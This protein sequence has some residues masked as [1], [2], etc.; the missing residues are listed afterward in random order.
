MDRLEK[1]HDTTVK[2][3]LESGAMARKPSLSIFPEGETTICADVGEDFEIAV[4]ARHT[5]GMSPTRGAGVQFEV[6]D[7]PL[8]LGPRRVRK[9]TAEADEEGRASVSAVYVKRGAATVAVDLR[10]GHLGDTVFFGGHS[11]GMTHR[12]TVA[13]WALSTAGE[14][15]TVPISVNALD[16]HNRPVRAADIL[17]E[18]SLVGSDNWTRLR[19][20]RRPDGEY[21]GALRTVRAGCWRLR[22]YD[23]ITK[24]VGEG[25]TQ[26][27]AA[28]PRALRVLEAPDPRSAPPFGEVWLRARLEDAH[29][30][31][32][33]PH[34]VRC[35]IKGAKLKARINLDGSARFLLHRP[36]GSG[37]AVANLSDSGRSGITA[38]HTVPF[39]ACWVGNPGFVG[40]GASF[41]TSVYIMPPP[42]RA[43]RT[44]TITLAFEPD[45]VRLLSLEPESGIAMQVRRE[46]RKVVAEIAFRRP[47]TANEVP[48]GIRIGT[49]T[50]ECKRGGST[51]FTA[52]AQMSPETEPWK[53]CISQKRQRQKC[54]CINIINKEADLK[55]ME[56]GDRAMRTVV[57]ILSTQNI[58]NCCP[59]LRINIHHCRIS[60]ADWRTKVIPAVGAGGVVGSS[61]RAQSP[62]TE[63]VTF[64]PPATNTVPFPSSSAR[65][66][67]RLVFRLPVSCHVPVTGL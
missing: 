5:P 59:S 16:L 56:A 11:D 3:T 6:I 27:L 67:I 18:A 15:N 37:N 14:R 21:E 42:R 63:P 41:E 38:I 19:L 9:L 47:V 46:K 2:K 62:E 1:G 4:H 25:C 28:N 10:R 13:T 22:A 7:G 8:R 64:V 51:C 31:P 35:R 53:L 30:N 60:K 58:K 43:I 55:A 52:T 65:G 54:L 29:G 24:T 66:P 44:A 23:R 20:R 36:Q 39:A 61:A 49:C 32:L 12:L 40:V 57:K 26:V 17:L 50:W 33:D 34:R 48:D 45:N